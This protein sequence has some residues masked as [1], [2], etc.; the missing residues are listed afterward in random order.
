M[1]LGLSMNMSGSMKIPQKMEMLPPS[2]E[3]KA[4]LALGLFPVHS[5]EDST[6][7][8]VP[9][10]QT[11]YSLNTFGAYIAKRQTGHE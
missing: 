8:S 9:N 1:K 3:L 7:S 10:N 4:K 5:A 2:L 11:H 6:Q